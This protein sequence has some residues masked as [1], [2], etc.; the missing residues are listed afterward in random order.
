MARQNDWT[1]RD[2]AEEEADTRDYAPNVDSS[3]VHRYPPNIHR[4]PEKHREGDSGWSWNGD[5]MIPGGVP[6][7]RG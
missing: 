2:S 4:D 5:P 6:T 3:H 1:F 7:R